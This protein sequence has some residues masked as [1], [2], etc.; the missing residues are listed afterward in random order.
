MCLTR[1]N[2]NCCCQIVV[3]NVLETRKQ[4]VVIVTLDDQQP[5]KLSQSD[6]ENGREI[7]QYIVSELT[8]RHKLFKNQA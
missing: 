8:R 1:A 3:A 6:I 5:I 7:E 4:E 2:D